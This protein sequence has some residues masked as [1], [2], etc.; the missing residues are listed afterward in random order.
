MHHHQTIGNIDDRVGIDRQII[1]G[2]DEPIV[3]SLEAIELPKRVVP[4]ALGR[5]RLGKHLHPVG[6]G[7]APQP[8]LHSERVGVLLAFSTGRR[9][10]SKLSALSRYPVSIQLSRSPTT[11][12]QHS[13]TSAGLR[14]RAHCGR[15]VGCREC[16]G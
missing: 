16:D 13:N 7:I 8:G 12:H 6:E 15:S 2:D 3:G 10:S 14:Y 1:R 5:Q 4:D 11:H 9:P